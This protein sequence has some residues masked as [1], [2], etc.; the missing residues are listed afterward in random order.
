MPGRKIRCA[1]C[2]HCKM[3]W[4]ASDLTGSRERRVRCAAGGW[5]TPSGSEKDYPLY[6]L[7]AR[8]MDACPAFSSMGEE[9]EREFLRELRRELPLERIVESLPEKEWPRGGRRVA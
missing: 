2:L 7:L 8:T 5:H 1:N 3:T 6:T 4:M 9:D